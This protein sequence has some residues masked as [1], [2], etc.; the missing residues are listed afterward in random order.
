MAYRG[1]KDI[2]DMTFNSTDL[3]AYVKGV[4]GIEQD[5]VLQD[6]KPAG[7]AWA[8]PADTGARTQSDI[9]ITYMYDGS[10][11]GPNVKCALGTSATLTITFFSGESITG[12]FIVSKV[13]VN[14]TPDGDNELVV[15]F[16]GSGTITLDLTT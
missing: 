5:A 6:F 4:D 14:V 11:S 2:V 8:T 7:T 9:T 10:A 12:T 16:T 15:V 1:W 13:S 3:K